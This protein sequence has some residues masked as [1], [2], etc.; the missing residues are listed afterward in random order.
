[1]LNRIE[2]TFLKIKH[3]LF[4]CPDKDLYYINKSYAKCTICDRKHFIFKRY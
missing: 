3:F 4:G 2:L 1:M